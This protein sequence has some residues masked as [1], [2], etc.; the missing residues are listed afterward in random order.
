MHKLMRILDAGISK[1][2]YNFQGTL[3]NMY[4]SKPGLNFEDQ[5]F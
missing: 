5:E 1:P 4:F 3:K 2:A